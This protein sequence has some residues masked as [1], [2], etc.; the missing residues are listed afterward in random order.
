[1]TQ[2]SLEPATM[3]HAE[4]LAL[5]MRQADIGEVWRAAHVKPLEA[6]Q[7]SMVASRDTNTGLADG[8]VMCM[9]GVAPQTALAATGMMWLLGHNDLPKH[10]RILLRGGKEYV[11]QMLREYAT[12]IAAGDS[13]NV[14][15]LRWLQWL[16]FDLGPAVPFGPDQTPFYLAKMAR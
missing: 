10:S 1:M 11:R 12:L 3:A 6:I 7:K 5:N 9:F 2:Y 16:G 13:R 8:R 14:V 4:E 15:A